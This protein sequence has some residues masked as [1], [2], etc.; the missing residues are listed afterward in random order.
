MTVICMIF[1]GFLSRNCFEQLHT[2]FLCQMPTSIPPIS[3]PVPPELLNHFLNSAWTES[4][5]HSVHLRIMITQLFL[6]SSYAGVL[7]W[8]SLACDPAAA[9]TAALAVPRLWEGSWTSGEGGYPLCVLSNCCRGNGSCSGGCQGDGGCLSDP[10][11]S[12]CHQL[13]WCTPQLRIVGMQEG[14]RRGQRLMSSGGTALSLLSFFFL[15][16]YYSFSA[17]HPSLF[18][19][20]WLSSPLPH[21]PFISHGC[22]RVCI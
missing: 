7:L 19:P 3:P 15:L 4:P 22:L 20:L 8:I 5:G 1:V 11:P 13:Y 16:L 17:T 2:H 9:G 18:L 6:A 21:A 12:C 10:S 14:G